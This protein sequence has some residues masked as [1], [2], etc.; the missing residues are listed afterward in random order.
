MAKHENGLGKGLEGMGNV[1]G[2]SID[3]ML[4]E[5]SSGSGENGSVKL[6]IDK[7]RRNPYQPRKTFDEEKLQE[8]AQSIKEHGVF[9]PILVR[10]AIEGY[11]LVAGER[12][13]RASK[14]AGLNEIPAIVVKFD[15]Q[16]MME[17]SLLENIQREDLSPIEEALAYEELIN[18]LDYTQEKLAHRLGKSRSNITNMLRLL[19]LPK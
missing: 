9:Q 5:I 19:K 14:I 8:L 13:L 16:Q 12:R 10:E 6:P 1:F 3:E 7:I 17:I 15:E 11:E 4:D 2:V 18:K